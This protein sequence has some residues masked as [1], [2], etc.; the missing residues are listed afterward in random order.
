MTN[1][2]LDAIQSTFA[3]AAVIAA[4]KD[5]PALKTHEAAR[6]YGMSKTTLEAWRCQGRGPRFFK[7]GKLILYRPRDIEAYLEQGIVT[8]IDQP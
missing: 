1:E 2:I 7:D 5:K 3:D 6:L 8:T 4:L